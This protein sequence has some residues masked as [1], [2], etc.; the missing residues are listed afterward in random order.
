MTDEDARILQQHGFSDRE[1]VDTA[2]AAGARNMYS[3]SLH[4]LGVVPDIPTPCRRRCA[5]WW[6]AMRCW[7]PCP[8]P[9]WRV[10]AASGTS[11]A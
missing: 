4:A 1:I 6:S 7:T 10:R 9:C 5:A 2:F 8:S 3:R 11:A